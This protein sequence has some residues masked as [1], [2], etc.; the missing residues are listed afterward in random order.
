LFSLFLACALLVFVFGVDYHTR[1]WTNS[2]GAFKVGV[3][4]LFLL[5][6]LA[7]R[8]SERG[9]V[10]APIAL[11]FLAASLANVT[12]WYLAEPLQRWLWGVMGVSVAMPEGQMWG[13]LVDVVLKLAP[14]FLLL[15][16]AH[17]DLGSVF[18]R[19]GKL[20]WSLGIGLLALFNFVATAI[21]V[22]ASKGGDMATLFA[23]LPWWFAFSL[24]NAFMEEIWFRGLF[25]R[26][27]EPAV[28]AAGALL[29]T[30]LA[31]GTSHL[32]ATYIDL[33]GTVTFGIITCTLG[34][35]WALLMHKTDTLWGSV[36]F[37]TAADVYG[38]VAI[39]F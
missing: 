31:F 14:I 8:R 3:S 24:I 28:G 25:L 5:A 27:L 23:N 30:T 2:S 34:L 18:I 29:L 32:F 20:R 10:Y 7:L 39:G 15:W 1:F 19:R 35:A 12:T 36:V 13:K 9:R 37:H 33:W 22:A 21:A 4:A 38:V 6:M 26:R 11:A 16:L 17:E